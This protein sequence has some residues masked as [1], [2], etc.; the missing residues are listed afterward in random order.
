MKVS[1]CKQLVIVKSSILTKNA[2]LSYGT[3]AAF[4]NNFTIKKIYE[5]CIVVFI[6]KW[7]AIFYFKY[8]TYKNTVYGLLKN[9]RCLIKYFIFLR[10]VFKLT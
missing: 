3:F 7:P 6:I 2:S 9:D 4:V 8:L 5:I 1:Y 10:N